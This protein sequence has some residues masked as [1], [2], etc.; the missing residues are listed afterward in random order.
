VKLRAAVFDLD[1]TLVDNMA[2][3]LQAWVQMGKKLG[4]AITAEQFERDFAGRKNEEIFPRLLGREVPPDE[5]QRLADEKESTYRALYRA[6]VRPMPGVTALLDTLAARGIP[7]AIASA[8][9]EGNRTLV[10]EALGWR[11]RFA[12]VVGPEGLRGKPFPDIF[13]AAAKAIGVDPKDCLAFEDAVHGVAAAHAAGMTVVGIRST[14]PAELLHAAGARWTARD[15][16]E[17][18]AEVATLLAG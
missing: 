10:L 1:G 15:F 3:H 6:H 16:T 13:L 12:A 7:C 8:A 4:H 5:L 18:P 2:F 9:P 11:P 17:L 14:T